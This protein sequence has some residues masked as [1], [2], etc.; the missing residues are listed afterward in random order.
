MFKKI[1]ISDV[2]FYLGLATIFFWALAK[3]LGIIHS[4]VWQE[5]LPYFGA[6]FSGGIAWSR[7]TQ[8]EKRVDKIARGLTHLEREF[9]EFKME[10]KQEFKNINKRFEEVERRLAKLE[11][12]KA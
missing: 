8:L 11:S 6:V 10:T 2:L 9:Y 1:R 4:P 5:M 3:A 12:Y 7:F